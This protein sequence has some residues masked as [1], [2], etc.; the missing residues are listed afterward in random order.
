M[1]TASS[2]IKGIR[3]RGF[4]P[5]WQPCSFPAL[6]ECPERLDQSL[7][8]AQPFH[9][10]HPDCPPWDLASDRKPSRIQ[11]QH[12]RHLLATFRKVTG[13]LLLLAA[14]PPLSASISTLPDPRGVTREENP[15][16]SAPIPPVFSRISSTFFSFS[17]TGSVPGLLFSDIPSGLSRMSSYS[18]KEVTC[19]PV[20]FKQF[21]FLSNFHI[22]H[23]NFGYY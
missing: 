16:V 10:G 12:N 13:K 9:R 3:G 4:W 21:G 19:L 8:K 7:S 11:S 14:W 15:V 22:P 5:W 23:I 6:L 20:V 2:S 17:H 18:S 1:A